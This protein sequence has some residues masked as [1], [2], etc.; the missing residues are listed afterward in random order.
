MKRLLLVILATV[1]T[2]SYAD[3][4]MRMST[5]LSRQVVD[6]QPVDWQRISTP[7]ARGQK[8][9]I[10]YR[11]QY[12][13]KWETAEGV[14]YG[15]NEGAACAQALDLS[16]GS[17]LKEVEPQRI[18]ADS[19][20]ICSDLLDITVHPVRIG[21]IIYQSE[22]D[23]HTIPSERKDFWYKRTQ[24]R[25]FV[26]KDMKNTNLWLYQGVICRINTT[27][28]SKWRVIDKY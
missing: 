18:S 25:M 5:R 10:R 24:C 28:N 26:E 27:P 9:V 8:C 15:A 11:I 20:M 13:G 2:L 14:G 6:S 12:Q 23:M 21:D 16:N 22:V 7:D 1:S 3:C 17:L 19:Q 4:Y